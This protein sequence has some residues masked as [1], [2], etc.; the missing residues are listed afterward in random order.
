MAAVGYFCPNA[1]ANECAL[2]SKVLAALRRSAPYT[3]RLIGWVD[4]SLSAFP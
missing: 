3:G 2:L 4:G 1:F